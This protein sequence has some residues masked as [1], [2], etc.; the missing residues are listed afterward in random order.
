LK[1][2]DNQK[3]PSKVCPMWNIAS[4]EW[5]V[6]WKYHSVTLAPNVVTPRCICEASESVRHSCE[7]LHLAGSLDGHA[8]SIPSPSMLMQYMHQPITRW[9]D[10][11]HISRDFI[12]S[13]IL[14]SLALHH[15]VG[16]SASSLAQ[17]SPS[18]AVP[19]FKVSDLPFTLA[20]G[21]SSQVMSWSSPPWSHESMSCLMCNKL[22]HHHMCKLCNISKPFSPS[23]HML[24]T[25]TCTC[26]LITCVSHI[27]HN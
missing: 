17:A 8:H 27:K 10:P 15:C 19:R 14:T 6:I 22:N 24:L 21:P 7:F 13:L 9:Y 16:P 4:K 1:D 18:H 25:H 5:T 20:T 2:Y 26:R 12:G 3:I 23:W 11:F